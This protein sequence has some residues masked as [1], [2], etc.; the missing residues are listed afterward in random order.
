M[1]T[2]KRYEKTDAGLVFKTGGRAVYFV[3]GAAAAS[4]F[5]LVSG[6]HARAAYP[7]QLWELVLAIPPLALIA[8]GAGLVL[9]TWVWN[10]VGVLHAQRWWKKN[11]NLRVRADTR[12]R[13]QRLEFTSGTWKERYE[14]AH[15]TASAYRRVVRAI[16]AAVALEGDDEVSAKRM[17]GS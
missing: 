13:I 7:T 17:F 11:G 4:A 12:A 10:Q 5:W 14:Q 3:S 15:A 8:V 9:W 16:N 1:S 2:K 6:A